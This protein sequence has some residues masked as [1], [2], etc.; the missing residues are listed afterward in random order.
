M[1]SR[2]KP[3]MKSQG[4]EDSIPFVNMLRKKTTPKSVKT[5]VKATAKTGKAINAS[6]R[7]IATTAF[8]DPKKGW[9]DVAV[10]TGTWLIPYG[11]GFEAVDKVIKGGRVIKETGAAVRGAK[12]VRKVTKGAKAATK[13]TAKKTVRGVVKGGIIAGGVTGS[14][15]VGAKIKSGKR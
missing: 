15:K 6:S 11:K 2:R 10:N 5:S 3:A 4:W 12:G 1:A 9:K 14:E 8:G 7:Y 13:A